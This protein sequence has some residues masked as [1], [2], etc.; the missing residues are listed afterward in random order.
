MIEENDQ[1]SKENERCKQKAEYDRQELKAAL[2]KG[3]I[4]LTQQETQINLLK[5]EL[6]QEKPQNPLDAKTR[7][8]ANP[9]RAKKIEQ[10]ELELKQLR[11]MIKNKSDEANKQ[12]AKQIE[13]NELELKQLR[14][15][16]QRKQQ[17]ILIKHQD[18]NLKKQPIHKVENLLKSLVAY[19]IN[20]SKNNK[21]KSSYI[22]KQIIDGIKN[23]TSAEIKELKSKIER[24]SEF[25]FIGKSEPLNFLKDNKS[26]SDFFSTSTYD[27]II[28]SL[29]AACEKKAQAE[30][31]RPQQAR[32]LTL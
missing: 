28:E 21:D 10:N 11:E 23:F 31:Q 19:V 18:N 5:E 30:L 22:K 26:S 16:A 20:D 7:I 29:D 4:K 13:Q 2:E 25:N 12:A 6:Q 3:K 14:E 27:E 15:M 1:I 32:Q 9:D 17:A 8:K 24:Y